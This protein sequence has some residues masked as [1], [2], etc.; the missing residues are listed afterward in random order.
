MN[1]PQDR[2]AGVEQLIELW[3]NKR[4]NVQ[5]CVRLVETTARQKERA[6]ARLQAAK[7]QLEAVEE[8]MRV[9]GLPTGEQQLV[10]IEIADAPAQATKQRNLSDPW[11]AVLARIAALYPGDVGLDD[12]GRWCSAIGLSANPDTIRSNMHEN[13]RRGLI[14][15]SGRGRFKITQEGCNAVAEGVRPDLIERIKA[16]ENEAAGDTKSPAAIESQP[17]MP[18][19][20][21]PA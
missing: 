20:H 16:L 8:A 10:K 21:K 4:D 14:E 12:I 17:V 3:R 18:L 7:L 19:P 11:R 1:V 9:L 2:R 15:S 5:D 6:E 13:K